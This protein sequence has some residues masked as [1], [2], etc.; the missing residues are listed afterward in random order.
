MVIQC[1][2]AKTVLFVFKKK[3]CN[4]D[5]PE[6]L[7]THLLLSASLFGKAEFKLKVRFDVYWHLIKSEW[8]SL[9]AEDQ[10]HSNKQQS[11]IMEKQIEHGFSNYRTPGTVCKTSYYWN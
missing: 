11:Q 4:P 6:H 5:Q 7:E 2:K 9:G 1:M 8:V 10:M 3:I